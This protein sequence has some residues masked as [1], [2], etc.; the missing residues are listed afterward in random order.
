MR[1]FAIWR[2][3]WISLALLSAVAL[4]TLVPSYM[5]YNT[6][7]SCGR[8]L[9]QP[10]AAELGEGGGWLIAIFICTFG[11]AQLL[12]I[13]AVVNSAAEWDNA[14]GDDMRSRAGARPDAPSC[15]LRARTYVLCAFAFTATVLLCGLPTVFDIVL[16]NMPPKN[17]WGLDVEDPLVS[18]SLKAVAPG[19]MLLANQVVLPQAAQA[20][21]TRVARVSGS[22]AP[23]SS[24]MAA[25]LLFVALFI[26]TIL[27]PSVT[28]I[29]FSTSCFQGFFRL[30]TRC[31]L[32]HVHELDTNATIRLGSSFSLNA[33]VLRGADLCG[34]TSLFSNFRTGAARTRSCVC[35]VVG[36]NADG[37]AFPAGY[38][39]RGFIEW[40]GPFMMRYLV[41]GRVFP[42][43]CLTSRCCS[44]GALVAGNFC[45]RLS[46]ARPWCWC[47]AY[48]SSGAAAPALPSRSTPARVFQ[49]FYPSSKW[50]C[51]SARLCRF[52]CQR[53]LLLCGRTPRP[54]CP[55]CGARQRQL[56]Q[57]FS[58]R[59]WL[60]PCWR[61]CTSG[62]SC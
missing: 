45:F 19:L 50:R 5:S 32:G 11:T 56:R 34:D 54:P 57:S 3:L 62:R 41:R 58:Q 60:A 36:G 16:E 28:T 40:V 4:A 25:V 47:A 21:S 13:R 29:F 22:R 33:A 2:T 52:C 24:P 51:A 26:N 31:E 49:S 10:T 6:F 30:W 1:Y 43:L 53:P 59:S 38:C 55:W 37:L 18:Y 27:M 20:I 8:A 17:T 7:H 9:S 14:G 15:C 48:G 23:A 61:T 44:R 12:A 42:T 39:S 35:C 46:S